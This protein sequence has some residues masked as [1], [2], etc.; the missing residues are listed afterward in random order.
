V[1]PNDPN[2]EVKMVQ[3]DYAKF[4][5]QVKRDLQ[6]AVGEEI[7]VLDVR[8]PAMFFDDGTQGRI[9]TFNQKVQETRNAQQ[10][11]QTAKAQELSAE[12]LAKQPVPDL[13]IAMAA[14]VNEA[15]ANHHPNDAAGC[16]GQIGGNSDTLLQ[17]PVGAR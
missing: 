4:A 8:I 11:I 17:L 5:E 3:P 9:D 2:V 1:N 14:C 15:V 13:K 12:Q 16:W 10:Q 7:E 6:G